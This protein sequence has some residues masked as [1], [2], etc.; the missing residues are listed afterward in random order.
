[1]FNERV[2]PNFAALNK[3]VFILKKNW[4]KIVAFGLLVYTIWAGF[5]WPVPRL[6]ILNETIR[7][8]YFHVCMWFAMMILFGT[9]FV[10]SIKY[11]RGFNYRNDIFA[12]QFAAVGAYL[13]ILGYATGCIWVSVTWVTEQGQSFGSVL[14]EPKL[15]GAAIALLIYGAYFVLRGSFTDIDKRARISAVFNIFAFAMLFPSI[16]IIPRLVGS[17]HP[18]APGSDS[19]NP[20]LDRNDMDSTMRMV[21]YPAVIGW[22]LLGVWIATLKIRIQLLADKTIL[23]DKA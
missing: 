8:L 3:Q 21:F 18:G 10:Y 22:T 16:W 14:K 19:G 4:W 15:I 20:A 1:L 5:L 13:G 9:S 7:N 6:P 11:L 17:L 2:Y 12:R 23:H